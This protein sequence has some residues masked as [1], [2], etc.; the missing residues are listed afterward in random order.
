MEVKYTTIHEQ[1]F[2]HVSGEEDGIAFPAC[3]VILVVKRDVDDAHVLPPGVRLHHEYRATARL[4][5]HGRVDALHRVR[6]RRRAY[7]N[8]QTTCK[9]KRCADNMFNGMYII[10]NYYY[11][12]YLI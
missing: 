4:R 6:Q 12:H 2:G 8:R 10:I 3:D 1:T 11:I 5:H 9:V 7:N